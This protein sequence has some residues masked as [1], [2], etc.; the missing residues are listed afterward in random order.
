MF[1]P[2]FIAILMG[3]IS[4]NHASKCN[5]GTVYV[6]TNDSGAQNDSGDNPG[7]G[8]DDGTGGGTGGGG[9]TG[10]GGTSGEGSQL[11]PPKP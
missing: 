9:S 10:G 1:L 5:G 2:V 3:F 7:T 6:T 4:P 11:P 8:D